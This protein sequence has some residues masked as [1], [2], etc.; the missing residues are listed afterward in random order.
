MCASFTQE[1]LVFGA[2]AKRDAAQAWMPRFDRSDH[3]PPES[4]DEIH[5]RR[6]SAG[7]GMPLDGC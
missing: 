6:P 2:K 5:S 7:L 3:E 1:N 4:N